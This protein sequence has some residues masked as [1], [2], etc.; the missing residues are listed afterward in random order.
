VTDFSAAS[1]LRAPC[2][3]QKITFQTCSMSVFR[4]L[5][6]FL[7]DR[8]ET[9]RGFRCAQACLRKIAGPG[10]AILVVSLTVMVA[11]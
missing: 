7:V 2:R 1:R 9:R 8:F 11:T 4:S 6:P 3:F 5:S 10:D